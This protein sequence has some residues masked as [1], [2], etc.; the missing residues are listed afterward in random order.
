MR[1]NGFN[2]CFERGDKDE[3]NANAEEESGDENGKEHWY[4]GD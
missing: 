2:K 4:Y 1:W 3:A